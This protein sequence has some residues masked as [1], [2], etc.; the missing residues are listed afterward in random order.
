MSLNNTV[1]RSWE[2][3]ADLDHLALHLQ[4][5]GILELRLYCQRRWAINLKS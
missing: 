1:P 4:A 2:S 5:F 3:V